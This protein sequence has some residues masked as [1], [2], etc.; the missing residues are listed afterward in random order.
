MERDDLP[1]EFDLRINIKQANAIMQALNLYY[2]IL[3]GQW[4]E[5]RWTMMW[6]AETEYTDPNNKNYLDHEKL[7][8][9]EDLLW[10]AR[11]ILFPDLPSNPG[12]SL[13]IMSSNVPEICRTMCDVND[14][15]R[16][17]L[18]WT[19][20]PKGGEG[21]DFYRPMKH[22]QE[23]L[24]TM[25]RVQQDY[26]LVAL[27]VRLAK[28]NTIIQCSLP[29]DEIVRV[30]HLIEW[31]NYYGGKKIGKSLP[32]WEMIYGQPIIGQQ[33]NVGLWPATLK[34][35]AIYSKY[36]DKAQIGIRYGNNR[37][38]LLDSLMRRE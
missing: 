26:R 27:L 20:K 12:C 32:R 16:Y 5:I 10:T 37:N 2:R 17:C 23:K 4:G 36:F 31:L 22:G 25:E 9:A 19:T 13:G 15:V 35:I 21:V 34:E 6:R 1:I 28:E 29:D 14:V 38:D 24:A 33:L 7:S 11:N 18:A 8:E 30:K 3:M